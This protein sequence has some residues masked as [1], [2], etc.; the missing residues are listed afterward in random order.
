MARFIALGQ[1][2]SATFI[3]TSYFAMQFDNYFIRL[4]TIDDLESFFELV[5]KNRKRLESFFT[6]T[7]SRTQT[8][9]D[10]RAFLADM[11]QRVQSKTYFPYIIVEEGSKKLVGF[12]DLK[13]LDW[14]IPKSEVGCYIDEDYA[15]QGITTKA[16]ALFCDHSFTEYGFQKLFLRTHESNTAARRVAEK[17]G[18]EIE[19][20]IR[21]DYKTTSGEL[22]DLIYYGRLR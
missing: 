16:F 11:A 2:V 6:G 1:I 17:C 20:T 7:V 22:V 15:R 3:H 18:F 13:N 12:L 9:E 21:K 4:L 19:G 14:S 8:K 5:Q 10:T